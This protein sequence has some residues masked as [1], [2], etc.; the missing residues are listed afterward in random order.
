MT[1]NNNLLGIV[2]QNK[3]G[4]MVERCHISNNKNAGIICTSGSKPIF[5]KCSIYNGRDVGALLIDKS[6]PYFKVITTLII[7]SG[8]PS[9]TNIVCIEECDF[10]SNK[11]SGIEI[12]ENSNPTIISSIIRDGQTG[13]VWFN[14]NGKGT[15]GCTYRLYYTC[16]TKYRQ[17]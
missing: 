7:P 2:F 6:E 11:C 3:S 1:H 8:R 13:G 15:S 17:P 16:M 5:R 10:Y 12:K 14:S 4:G 9:Y